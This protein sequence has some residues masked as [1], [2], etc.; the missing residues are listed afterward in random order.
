MKI[1]TFASKLEKQ[2]MA[3]TSRK[4]KKP[5][6]LVSK[7]NELVASFQEQAAPEFVKNP[8]LYT[9]IRGNFSLVQ[10]GLMVAVVAQLQDKIND[11]IGTGNIQGSLFRPE[12]FNGNLL[13]FEIPLKDLGISPKKYAELEQAKDALLHMDMTYKRYNEEEGRDYYE[14]VNIFHKISIP[15]VEE[16]QDG[17]KVGYKSGTRRAGFMKID[18]VDECARDLLNLRLG[19]TEHLKDI[20]SLCRSPRT[21]RLYIYLSAFRW[22]GGCT[23]SYI[24]L[25][26]FFGLLKFNEAHT[27]VI[28]NQYKYFA[29]F[30]RDVLDPAQKEMKRLSDENKVEFYFEYE[31]IYRR[32]KRGDPDAIKFTIIEGQF[33]RK[34]REQRLENKLHGNLIDKYKLQPDEWKQIEEYLCGQDIK[35]EVERL[36]KL[37]AEKKPANVHAYATKVLLTYL[38]ANAPKKSEYVEYEEV[39]QKP[40]RPRISP[41]LRVQ[42]DMWMEACRD[43]VGEKFYQTFMDKS[44]CDIWTFDRVKKIVYVAVPTEFVQEKWTEQHALIGPLFFTHFGTDCTFQ[45]VVKDINDYE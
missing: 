32:V 12:D 28:S 15:V 39:P 24:D 29:A 16:K 41:Q 19:Y 27:K 44:F 38:K 11:K 30:H 26:E 17:T 21:P 31:P 25:K 7:T 8:V 40:L 9:Q 10:T 34:H 23:M 37:I 43:K 4:T 13:H 14:S 18:M 33:G 3:D 35:E 36:D 1:N 22:Q 5:S 20:A 2:K 6:G 45:Y 42:Y